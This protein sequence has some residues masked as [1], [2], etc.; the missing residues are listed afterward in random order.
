AR[1]GSLLPVGD[2]YSF[3]SPRLSR[4]EETTKGRGTPEAGP[5]FLLKPEGA[6]MRFSSVGAAAAATAA[7]GLAGCAAF[8]GGGGGGGRGGG[9]AP[10]LRPRLPAAPSCGASRGRT[11]MGFHRDI[12]RAASATAAAAGEHGHGRGAGL[13]RQDEE[14]DCGD[15]GGRY[16]R[17][18]RRRRRGGG[19][20]FH[21]GQG[22]DDHN[23]GPAQDGLLSINH[24]AAGGA[25]GGASLA[26]GDTLSS[27]HGGHSHGGGTGHSHSHAHFHVDMATLKKRPTLIRHV[28]VRDSGGGGGELFLASMCVLAVPLWRRSSRLEWAA[29]GG[30]SMFLAAVDISKFAISKL[31]VQVGQ[32]Y[33]GWKAHSDLATSS[34]QASIESTEA[35]REV[36]AITWVGALV[37]V[38]LAAFKLF[39]GI[40]GHSSAMIADA[41]HSLS[42]LLSDA[43][44]LW[45]VRLSRLPP[46]EDHPYGH[47][48]FEAVGAFII[49]LMLMGAGYGIGN[50]SFET[51]REVISRGAHAAIPTRLTAVAASVSII[52]K[53]A[54]FRATNTIGKRRNS[55]VLIANAWHHRTDAVSS[56]VALLAIAGSMCGAPMLDPIAG[57]MV[58]GMVALTGVQV[59]TDAMAQLTDAADYD[60]RRKVAE[61]ATQQVP[62]VLSFDR[63]RAR[64]M[65]PQTLVD[66]AIQTD[67]MISASAA[68]QV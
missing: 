11:T 28:R 44:T 35:A 6:R 49:A 13:R 59:S 25:G 66:L 22:H 54:L 19:P 24:G 52:A 32:L 48:R 57:L 41:G 8:G 4:T 61:I 26:L 2:T 68:Q 21:G 47:G 60:V 38:G 5:I 14:A 7:A 37:N 42:D 23:H 10:H 15:E 67:D 3:L 18:L 33:S 20:L 27:S 9:G 17:R 29:L 65:G 43:V 55:Q 36:D 58:A 63:V 16:F 46:D 50:H 39:A 64:R 56:V 34:Q 1:R 12:S 51:L 45:A 62:G 30:V 31:R 40:F 53:E